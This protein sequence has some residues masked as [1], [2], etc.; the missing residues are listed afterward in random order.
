[1]TPAGRTWQLM[2][3]PQN[4]CDL[5]SARCSSRSHSGLL[6]A[7]S[8]VLLDL[9]YFS[10]TAARCHCED[11]GSLC[12][13]DDDQRLSEFQQAVWWRFSSTTETERD[14]DFWSSPSHVTGGV[15]LQRMT[16]LSVRV[17]GS[18][19]VLNVWSLIRVHAAVS[20][21][22][23]VWTS[24]TRQWRNVGFTKTTENKATIKEIA[25]VCCEHLCWLTWL[26]NNF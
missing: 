21:T 6:A 8:L 9:L 5:L 11:C 17:G 16:D 3:T 15:T 14:S 20:A 23:M 18:V 22:E 7:D 19:Q 1:M 10:N 4:W 25:T 12:L 13:R 26:L 24:Q 2:S